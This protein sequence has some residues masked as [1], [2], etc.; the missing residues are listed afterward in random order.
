MSMH[1]FYFKSYKNISLT[2][3]CIRP[4][5]IEIVVACGY[6]IKTNRNAFYKCNGLLPK[7]TTWNVERFF[8]DFSSYIVS[9]GSSHQINQNKWKLYFL[10]ARA[11]K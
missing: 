6:V 3:Y 1:A 9:R 8:K 10:K 11:W 7:E 2:D 5:H 4:N